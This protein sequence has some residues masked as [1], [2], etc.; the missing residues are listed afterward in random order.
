MFNVAD[1]SRVLVWS[2]PCRGDQ[3]MPKDASAFMEGRAQRLKRSPSAVK[4]ERAQDF[5]FYF[6]KKIYMYAVCRWY[7]SWAV[8]YRLCRGMFPASIF[9]CSLHLAVAGSGW[10][11]YPLTTGRS[12]RSVSRCG[13]VQRSQCRSLLSCPSLPYL[14]TQMS[15]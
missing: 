12:Q 1:T 15:A 9:S 4:G 6:F 13:F 3:E 10:N 7:A 8:G 11:V 14:S 2:T 5:P